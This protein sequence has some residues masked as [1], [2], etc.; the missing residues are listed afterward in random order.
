MDVTPYLTFN[1]SCAA[2]FKCYEQT[3]GGKISFVQTF[4]DS[5]AKDQVPADWRDKVVHVRLEVGNKALMGSDAPGPHYQTPQG[6]SVSVSVPTFAE[7]RRIFDT[8]ADEGR[9]TMPFAQTFWS[10]GFGMLVDRFGT[11]WMI[12]CE[13]A[14]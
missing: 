6:I 1:G 11:P 4:G 5:P 7:A 8:L 3:L 14:A 9:V 12:G 13:Q 10:P 2:A